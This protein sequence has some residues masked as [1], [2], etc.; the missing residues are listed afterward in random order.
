VITSSRVPRTLPGRPIPGCVESKSRASK[1]TLGN[2]GGAGFGVLRDKLSDAG[3]VPDRSA[4]P[5]D[6]HRGALVSPDVPQD[7]SHFDTFSWLTA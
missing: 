6:P 7:L 3:E 4:S 2:D 1:D 5:Y